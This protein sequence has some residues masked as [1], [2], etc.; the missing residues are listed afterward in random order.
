MSA[1]PNPSTPPL[2]LELR[3]AGRSLTRLWRIAVPLG[4]GLLAVIVLVY[5]VLGPLLYNV[6]TSHA[7]AVAEAAGVPEGMIAPIGGVLFLLLAVACVPIALQLVLAAVNPLRRKHGPIVGRLLL[8]IGVSML[9][10]GLPPILREIRGVDAD[11]LPRRMRE[12]NPEQ[13]PWFDA[14]GEPRVFI[15][16][17]GVF[18]NRPGVAPNGA[19]VRPVT[20]SDRA[21]FDARLQRERAEAERQAEA[22]DRASRQAEEER[23]ARE[24][25]AREQ[26]AREQAAERQ[27][28]ELERAAAAAAAEL[29]RQAGERRR[30]QRQDHQQNSNNGRILRPED[31]A[32]E[33]RQQPNRHQHS[34][35]AP[36]PAPA[37]VLGPSPWTRHRLGPHGHI[38]ARGGPPRAI[39]EVQSNGH[40][41]LQLPDG[42]P[43]FVF[44]PGTHRFEVNTGEYRIYNNRQSWTLEVSTRWVPR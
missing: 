10:P 12:V 11:G 13:V 20:G 4:V 35:P 42:R 31:F 41:T 27:R 3:E 34:A 40:G 16:A 5:A 18:Y 39:V 37:P 26:A 38:Q 15:A 6:F 14:S 19:D 43:G 44:G 32:P 8:L 2:V 25:A 24:R 33:G 1:K 23:I 22:R 29:Q 21:A 30:Q 28:L 17:D 9:V 7:T 36:A